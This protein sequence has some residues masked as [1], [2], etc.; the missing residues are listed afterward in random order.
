MYKTNFDKKGCCLDS[1][2][3]MK[4]FIILYDQSFRFY[5]DLYGFSFHSNLDYDL[6]FHSYLDLFD[7]NIFLSKAL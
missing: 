1:F 4:A 6:S 2:H 7:I 3:L 5:L